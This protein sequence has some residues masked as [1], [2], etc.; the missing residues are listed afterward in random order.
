MIWSSINSGGGGMTKKF[1]PHVGSDWIDMIL[2]TLGVVISLIV[3]ISTAW[4][5][6]VSISGA[7]PTA[8]NVPDSSVSYR[9]LDEFADDDAR[10]AYAASLLDQRLYR[11]A[12]AFLSEFLATVETDSRLSAAIRY[13]RGLAYLYL[14]EY[15]EAISDFSAVTAQADYPDAYYNLGNALVGLHRYEEALEAY[16]VAIEL[17]EKPE[18]VEVRDAVLALLD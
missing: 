15:N 6:I 10:L 16:G 11:A 4:A 9:G 8:S 17:E 12:E 1:D 14:M 2:I 7:Q 18:Y 3:V 5:V 13:D